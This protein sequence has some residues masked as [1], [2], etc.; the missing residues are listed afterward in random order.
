M[1]CKK[2]QEHVTPAVDQ[3][4]TREEMDL[5]SEHAGKCPECR[6]EFELESITKSLIRSRVKMQRTPTDVV[7]RISDCL[8]NE[9][10]VQ[11]ISLGERLRL[12]L[13]STYTRPAIAFAVGCLAVIL[14]L[15]PSNNTPDTPPAPILASFVPGDVIQQ[16]LANYAKV[17][18]G[19]ITPQESSDKPEVLA[20]FFG[21]KTDFQVLVPKM[22]KCNLLGG[23]LNEFAGIKLAHVVYKHETEIVYMY[24][25]CWEEVQKG[26]KLGLPAE[27]MAELKKTGWYSAT[28]P[29]GCSIVLWTNN[30]TLC[31]A[32]AHMPKDALIACLKDGDDSN[33][34]P[35]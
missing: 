29:G 2:F 33:Q 23:V 17:L 5:F 13:S 26:E 27:A 18:N 22:K 14:L 20:G 10:P 28:Q 1:D 8:R 34:S 16:S 12:I 9:K 6:N 30:R 24:Q 7:E 21:G 11:Q 32:V 31:S 19:E 4:L 25:A 15:R 35:W 3:R